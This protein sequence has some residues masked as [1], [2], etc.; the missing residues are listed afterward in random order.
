MTSPWY[1]DHIVAL[2]TAQLATH[3]R[4]RTLAANWRQIAAAAASSAEQ[5]EALA[6]VLPDA[7]QASANLAV[8]AQEHHQANVSQ[9]IGGEQQLNQLRDRQ[10]D[11]LEVRLATIEAKLDLLIAGR[12]GEPP[13][14]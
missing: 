1:D 4:H 5:H 9:V 11:A 13:H 12:C 2:M 8:V 14:A 10:V 7:V 6:A 3:D